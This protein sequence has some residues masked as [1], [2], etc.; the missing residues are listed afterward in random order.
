MRFRFKS[1]VARLFSQLFIQVQMKEYI[2]APRH[3]PLWWEFT[4]DRW[5]PRTNGQLREKCFREKKNTH[6]GL[7]LRL[8]VTYINWCCSWH[9][10]VFDGG[11]S[12]VCC[13]CPIKNN[14]NIKGRIHDFIYIPFILKWL[15]SG[16]RFWWSR[17]PALPLK[18][19]MNLSFIS[20]L[21]FYCLFRTQKC[22]YLLSRC[23]HSLILKV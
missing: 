2:T 1:P 14:E 11:I 6:T 18:S 23:L 12:K 13:G 10:V 7:T 17:Y 3:W 15:K 16:I 8:L 9:R 4:G 5:N 22:S 21:C 19:L 20:F